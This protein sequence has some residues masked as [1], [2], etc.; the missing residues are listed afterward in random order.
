MCCYQWFA[1]L[2]CG[3]RWK[4]LAQGKLKY[5]WTNKN[6][7]KVTN[8]PVAFA[9]SLFPLNKSPTGVA[10]PFLPVREE[11]ILGNFTLSVSP[12]GIF[13]FCK[14]NL[15][16]ILYFRSRCIAFL[17]WFTLAQCLPEISSWELGRWGW[18]SSRMGNV[19]CGWSWALGLLPGA[20]QLPTLNIFPSQ[21]TSIEVLLWEQNGSLIL[22][23]TVVWYTSNSFKHQHL[24]LIL[25]KP[26]ILIKIQNT[27]IP[28]TLFFSFFKKFIL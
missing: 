23:C 2:L 5:K 18:S 26:L 28:D 11:D 17:L 10:V 27:M 12:S 3:L 4:G 16:T 9:R 25:I 1:W 22:F 14:L 20:Y 15:G 19:P 13:C 8:K 24:D 7:N 21:L 6:N